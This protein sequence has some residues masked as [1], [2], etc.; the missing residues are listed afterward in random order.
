[1]RDAKEI[2]ST[3]V[4]CKAPTDCSGADRQ[5]FCEF[6]RSGGEVDEKT[7]PYLIELARTLGFLRDAACALIGTGAI[8]R[9]YDTHRKSVFYNASSPLPVDLIPFEA[10]WFLIDETWRGCGLSQKLLQPL[11]TLV[12]EGIYATCKE[13]NQRIHS[14]LIRQGFIREG[15]SWLSASGEHN[16]VLFVRR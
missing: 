7:L 3:T 14:G 10:G 2:N 16:L 8:K 13:T 6:V 11:C 15:G 9:P 5:R 4:E 1:M 12:S